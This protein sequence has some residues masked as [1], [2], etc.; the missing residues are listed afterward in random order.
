MALQALS[1][2]AIASYSGG[3]DLSISIAALDVE[4]IVTI[5]K[6]DI[7]S[8]VEL[9]TLPTGLFT[10]ASGSGCALIQVTWGG[11]LGGIL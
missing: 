8:N 10:S 1:E 5:D 3:L 4:K 7:T 2:F 9:P 6:H 11:G